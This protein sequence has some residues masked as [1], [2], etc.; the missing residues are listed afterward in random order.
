MSYVR[1]LT[2]CLLL[3]YFVS[4]AGC[5]CFELLF[6]LAMEHTL[7]CM[8][9]NIWQKF[10]FRETCVM[11]LF[12]ISV[13]LSVEP[14]IAHAVSNSQY[15]RAITSV[16]FLINGRIQLIVSIGQFTLSV[17]YAII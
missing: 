10:C 13:Q 5:H 3:V 8:F 1:T 9:L 6:V 7:L 12:R 14:L 17:H 4:A 11:L 15:A 16:L 2:I